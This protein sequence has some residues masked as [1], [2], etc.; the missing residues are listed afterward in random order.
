MGTAAFAAKRLAQVEQL[1]ADDGTI[2]ESVWDVVVAANALGLP[3]RAS[4]EGHR[5]DDEPYVMFGLDYGDFE[6]DADA[7]AEIR[8]GNLETK[9]L[10]A[11]LLDEF[12]ADRA[13]PRTVRLRIVPGASTDEM[14]RL[15]ARFSKERARLLI[16]DPMRVASNFNYRQFEDTFS[17]R[18]G[19]N[20]PLPRLWAPTRHR[21]LARR[22]FE[23][24][25][26]GRFLRARVEATCGSPVCSPWSGSSR[27]VAP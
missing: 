3:T 2:E 4:C 8:R 7:V 11:E 17:I 5:R 6:P 22:Q 20:G 26:F 18:A 24:R 16:S 19:V 27:S 12:L 10:V 23:M 1:F 25:A 15:R 21:L 9:G 13:A 14:R